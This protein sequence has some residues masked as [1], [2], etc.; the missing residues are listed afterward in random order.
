MRTFDTAVDGEGDVA[1]VAN[2]GCRDGTLVTGTTAKAKDVS[3][4]NE[5]EAVS[6]PTPPSMLV[7]IFGSSG[8]AARVLMRPAR[9]P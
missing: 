5:A 9:P 1:I 2:T 4:S 3:R 6:S 8:R 7:E